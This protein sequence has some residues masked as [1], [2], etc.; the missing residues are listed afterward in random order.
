MH[1]LEIKDEYYE[2]LLDDLKE[3]FPEYLDQFKEVDEAYFAV[4]VF[5][6][7]LIE[8]FRKS[9]FYVRALNFINNA[10][11]QGGQ[12]TK[13][14][15]VVEVFEELFID[16]EIAETIR[17]SLREKALEIFDEIYFKHYNSNHL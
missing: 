5:G 7:L 9:E 13:D 15:F 16:Q 8:N 2:K 10:L 6:S 4:G 3:A 11:E 17:C 1:F 14:V 12:K